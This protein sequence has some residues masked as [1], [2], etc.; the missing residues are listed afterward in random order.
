MKISCML[1]DIHTLHI[2][3]VSFAVFVFVL[4]QM[5]SM[6]LLINIIHIDISIKKYNAT[7]EVPFGNVFLK[8]FYSQLLKF[9]LANIIFSP[10]LKN[11][12]Y[13]ISHPYQIWKLSLKYLQCI[14]QSLYVMLLYKN[15][16]IMFMFL[17]VIK[18]RYCIEI[19]SKN[20][21]KSFI[22]FYWQIS[23]CLCLY[24]CIAHQIGIYIRSLTFLK[25]AWIYNMSKNV[26]VIIQDYYICLK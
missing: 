23:N 11:S 9:L 16:C 5:R 20:R 24:A 21:K 4:N 10:Y 19:C 15:K 1:N 3:V 18:I 14:R 2:M 8:I 12:T 26:Y 22:Y 25:R 17:C 13:E 7:I 6:Y